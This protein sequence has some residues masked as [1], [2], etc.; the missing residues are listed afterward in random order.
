MTLPPGAAQVGFLFCLSLWLGW[1]GLLSWERR[2]HQR[3]LAG[4]RLRVHVNGTRGKSGVTRLIAAGL[5]G[6]FDHRLSVQHR[7]S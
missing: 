7:L 1:L 3:R 2:R 5:R 6:E 4:L